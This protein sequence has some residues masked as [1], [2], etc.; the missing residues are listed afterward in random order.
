MGRIERGL[1]SEA[2]YGQ[3]PAVLNNMDRFNTLKKRNLIAQKAARRY[4]KNLNAVNDGYYGRSFPK[5]VYADGQMPSV[6][7]K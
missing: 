5:S 4:T 2:F 6:S 3:N 1:R 7:V